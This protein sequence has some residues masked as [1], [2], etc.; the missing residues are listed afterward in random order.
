MLHRLF[1]LSKFILPRFSLGVNVG[2][3]ETIGMDLGTV[4]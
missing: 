2:R 3:K 4:L 1:P